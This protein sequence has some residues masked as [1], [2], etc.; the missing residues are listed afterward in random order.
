MQLKT[1]LAPGKPGPGN[2]LI[3]TPFNKMTATLLRVSPKHE[4]LN[5]GFRD[6]NP[7]STP[8]CAPHL[9]GRVHP[10]RLEGW[11]ISSTRRE[12]ETFSEIQWRVCFGVRPRVGIVHAWVEI[13]AR[14]IQSSYDIGLLAWQTSLWFLV[15]DNLRSWTRSIAR[16]GW[17]WRTS[18]CPRKSTPSY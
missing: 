4:C 8:Q 14:Q 10:R 1:P 18:D 9:E 5:S 11:T 15:C 13:Y 12:G 2:I 7:P 16:L 17:S 6:A 3:V